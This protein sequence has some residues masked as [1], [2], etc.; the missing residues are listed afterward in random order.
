MRSWSER[1]TVA[2]IPLWRRFALAAMAIAVA[3]VVLHGWI[4]MGLVSRGDDLLRAGDQN[5]ALAFYAR[6]VWFDG[7]W[8]TP[9]DRFTF[10]ASLSGEPATLARAIALSSAHLAR[11]TSSYDVRWDRAMCLLHLGRTRAAFADV[12]VLA[13]ARRSDWRMNAMAA[14][15]ASALGR[16]Q[17]VREFAR[18]ARPR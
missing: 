15:L 18:Y 12:A 13:R 17:A 11:D 3:T 9:A 4:A 1:L 5:R 10:A 8:D 6:A 16:A 2:P 7:G 14:Q